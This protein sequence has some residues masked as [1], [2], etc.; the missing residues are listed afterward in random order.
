MK[1]KYQ[2]LSG[3]LAVALMGSV[4]TSCTPAQQ[5]GAQYGAMAGAALGVLSGD[6]S[7]GVISKAGIGAAIGA[8]V[9]AVQEGQLNRPTSGTSTAPQPQSYPY[10]KQTSTPGYVQ[11]P[12]SPYNTLDVRGLSSGTKVTEPG[13]SNIFIIP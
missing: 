1:A 8:G 6:D 11:S 9:V 12:Y 5:Q 4:S 3:L 13:S 2:L 7:E 10:A